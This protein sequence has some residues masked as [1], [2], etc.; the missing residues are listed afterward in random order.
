MTHKSSLP[1]DNDD[2]NIIDVLE[3]VSFSMDKRLKPKV[4]LHV[5]GSKFKTSIPQN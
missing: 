4:L 3:S 2:S 1:I 5:D